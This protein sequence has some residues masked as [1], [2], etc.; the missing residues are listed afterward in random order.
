MGF[1]QAAARRAEATVSTG[2]QS[3]AEA[4]QKQRF[5]WQAHRFASEAFAQEA[6]A[7]RG[8]KWRY[9]QRDS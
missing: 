8:K 6:L 1:S 2:Q 9:H 4:I 7:R 5:H 3:E